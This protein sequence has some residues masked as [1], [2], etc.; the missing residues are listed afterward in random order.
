M[1]ERLY[2]WFD[3]RLRISRFARGASTEI[4]PD[5]WSFMLGEI[6]LYCF[7]V[8]VL[9]GTYLTFFFSPSSKEVVYHGSYKPLR[10]VSMSEAYQSTV[11]LS[12]DVRA[13]LVF[14]QMHHWAAL[15]F[16][17]AIVV[18]LCRVFF[19]GA[20]RRREVNWIVGVGLLVMVMFNGFSG[21]SL[22]DDLLSGTGLRVAYSIALAIPV[23]GTWVAFLFFGGEFPAAQL[24]VAAVRPPRD[25]GAGDHHRAADGPHGDPLAAEAHPVPRPGSD[26]EQHRR[27]ASV[28]DLRGASVGL[29]A[30]V[31]GVIAL[32][33]GLAQINPIWLYG[34]F[35]PAAVSTAAQPDW[36]MG[37]LEGGVA[38]GP[39]GAHPPVRYTISEL[40]W[41]GV[42]LRGS[43]SGCWRCGHS[44]RRVSP[45]IGRSITCSTNP[46]TGQCEPRSAS[47]CSPSTS[48]CSSPARRTSSPR[49]C[50]RPSRW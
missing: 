17:G 41:P 48:C 15:I 25:V 33:G 40:F 23:V 26:G 47:A 38:A 43:P 11:R 21:Y 10:G 19:T 13:G 34:P 9:T 32:L 12:F 7:V 30:G 44:W 22:P 28:A 29:L 18:H 46:V 4:F 6:A 49:R 1:L 27:V 2:E 39:S 36:Y 5:N 45:G 3:D 37:W 14:R 50:M 31:F 42:V 35:R 20:F 16:V 8:L 24:G